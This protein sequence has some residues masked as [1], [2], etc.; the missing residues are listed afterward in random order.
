MEQAKTAVDSF[1]PVALLV[2]NPSRWPIEVEVE[3]STSEAG[4]ARV[5]GAEDGQEGKGGDGPPEVDDSCP[6]YGYGHVLWSGM[7]R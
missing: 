1:V 3:V 4:G 5:S 7:P 2:H 6:G